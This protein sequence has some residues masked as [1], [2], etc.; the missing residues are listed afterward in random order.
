MRR[1]VRVPNR[2]PFCAQQVPLSGQSECSPSGSQANR[3]CLPAHTTNS[4]ARLVMFVPAEEMVARPTT[5]WGFGIPQ[6]ARRML[7]QSPNCP[8]QL[9][10]GAGLVLLPWPSS[11]VNLGDVPVGALPPCRMPV[12]AQPSLEPHPDELRLTCGGRMLIKSR[13]SRIPGQS[14]I[15]SPIM[16]AHPNNAATCVQARVCL[17]RSLSCGVIKASSSW[18]GPV[19]SLPL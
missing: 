3:A 7:H 9:T 13:D 18:N 16:V 1:A 6:V 2:H 10:L 4:S 12:L 11:H 19:A 14:I 15:C 17:D 8:A 5:W